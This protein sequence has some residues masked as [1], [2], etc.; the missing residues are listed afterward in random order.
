MI[1]ECIITCLSTNLDGLKPEMTVSCPRMRGLQSGIEGFIYSLE[2]HV[3]KLLNNY[4][5][6]WE[7]IKYFVANKITRWYRTLI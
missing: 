7:I 1:L 4:R 6:T 5:L 3:Y 2:R